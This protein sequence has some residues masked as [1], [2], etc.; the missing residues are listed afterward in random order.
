MTPAQ[1]RTLRDLMLAELP[2]VHDADFGPTTVDAGLCGACGAAP[3][4]IGVCGPVAFQAVCAP[5]CIAH[6]EALFCDGHADTAVAAGFY[7]K[8]LPSN[9]AQCVLLWWL[10]TGEVAATSAL[11]VE[12]MFAKPTAQGGGVNELVRR[13]AK[14]LGA[15]NVFWPIINK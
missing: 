5:C 9:W 2:W 14:L 11:D 6:G 3:A 8:A 7:C 15:D 12:A 13:N 4:L 10:A 1:R